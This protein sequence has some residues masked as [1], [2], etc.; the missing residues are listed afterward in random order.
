MAKPRRSK[1]SR[2]ALA[3]RNSYF[4]IAKRPLQI[5]AFLLPLI[6]VYELALT[7]LLQSQDNV[8]TVL[9][10][11]YLLDFFDAFNVAPRGGLHLGGIA[12]VVV[13]IIW[14]VLER[15]PWKIS[16]GAMG[17]MALESLALTLPLLVLSQLISRAGA[18]SASVAFE[19]TA[20]QGMNL[21]SKIAISIGAGLYEELVFRML[22]IAVI[23]TLLVDV[24]KASH[25]V[26]AIVA[27]IVSAAAFTAYHRFE[28]ASKMTF[29]FL[30]GAYFGG[31]Y[32]LRGFGIVAATHAFYDVLAVSLWP[33][34][35]AG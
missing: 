4:E 12:I 22:L 17:I 32:V 6:F 13:L 28:T 16:Y 27:V 7:F 18:S 24:G 20:L 3:E 1:S 14:H 29:Y 21:T 30:A 31:L 25:Q 5:L 26:G 15:R 33:D 10:H 2:L 9:A 34:H 35:G 11:R 8:R 23:H 19:P